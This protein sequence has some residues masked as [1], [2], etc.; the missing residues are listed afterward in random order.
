MPIEWI[1]TIIIGGFLIIY[2]IAFIIFV[3]REESYL[4]D[5]EE[6]LRYKYKEWKAMGIIP[7]LIVIG[8][9][10]L[11]ALAI[12]IWLIVAQCKTIKEYEKAFDKR[13]EEY[14]MVIFGDEGVERYREE[15]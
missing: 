13:N 6:I 15:Q 7:L 3:I 9:F 1:M 8:F 11:I 12:M 4:N 14:M 2:I 5:Y 10:I